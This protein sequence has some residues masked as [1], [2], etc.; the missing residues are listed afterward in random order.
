MFYLF[1]IF[2]LTSSFLIFADK[3]IAN[4]D[5]LSQQVEDPDFSL[6]KESSSLEEELLSFETR[7]V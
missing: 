6:V 3:A 5:P 4:L 2:L 1:Y 7:E